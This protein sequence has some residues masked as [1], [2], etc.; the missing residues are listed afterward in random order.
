MSGKE[1][2]WDEVRKGDWLVVEQDVPAEGP[3]V[4]YRAVWAGEVVEHNAKW[5]YL[6]YKGKQRVVPAKWGEETITRYMKKDFT[7][8]AKE[9]GW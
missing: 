9:Q 2:T 3:R 6:K 5:T 1:I 8:Y 7:A 4:F